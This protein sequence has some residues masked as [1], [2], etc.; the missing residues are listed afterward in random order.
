MT[1][2]ANKTPAPD[3]PPENPA[4]H[5]A[6]GESGTASSPSTEPASHDQRPDPIHPNLSPFVRALARVAARHD[7][8]RAVADIAAAETNPK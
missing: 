5:S 8:A 1:T 2:N 3:E 6:V 4:A 7:W